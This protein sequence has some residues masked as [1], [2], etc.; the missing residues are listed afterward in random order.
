MNNDV[1]WL[2]RIYEETRVCLSLRYI[3]GSGELLDRPG[4]SC[5]PPYPLQKN[6]AFFILMAII[7]METRAKHI[8]TRGGSN[9]FPALSKA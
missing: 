7:A 9:Q 5:D 1:W 4:D 3:N 8:Y 6:E 2:R